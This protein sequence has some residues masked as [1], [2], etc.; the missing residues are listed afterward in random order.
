[1]NKEISLFE[2]KKKLLS[3]EVDKIKENKMKDNDDLVSFKREKLERLRV[4]FE[5]IDKKFNDEKEKLQKDF[6]YNK[7]TI[8]QKS[9]LKNEERVS[10]NTLLQEND[11]LTKQINELKEDK[12]EKKKTIEEKNRIK[13]ELEKENQELEK[14]KFV[15][16]YKIKETIVYI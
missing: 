1:M 12:E 7:E 3:S 13:K 4:D 10:L 14:F 11:K 9:G 5:N 16:N 15:L 8:K 6:F 2:E